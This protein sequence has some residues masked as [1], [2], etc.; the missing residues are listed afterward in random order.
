MLQLIL[1]THLGFLL[2]PLLTLA[3]EPNNPATYCDRFM[4]DNDKAQCVQKAS[5]KELDWYASSAC[6]LQQEDKSFLSCLDEIKGATFNPEA[7]EL[8]AN[9]TDISDSARMSCLQ[10]IKNKDYSR[11]QIQKCSVAG[12]QTAIEGCLSNNSRTPASAKNST[13]GFQSLEVQK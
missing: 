9:P 11:A 12:S 10:K 4:G 7:L 6:S 1:K 3:I 5:N 2:I 13:Q 8:C